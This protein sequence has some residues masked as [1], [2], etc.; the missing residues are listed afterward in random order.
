MAGITYGILSLMN[1]GLFLTAFHFNCRSCFSKGLWYGTSIGAHQALPVTL[2]AR[3][4]PRP[5]LSSP[6]A[7]MLPHAISPVYSAKKHPG[8]SRDCG[9][10]EAALAARCQEQCHPSSAAL[11]EDLGQAGELAFNGWLIFKQTIY[12]PHANL[13][14]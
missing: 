1:L 14:Y 4:Q 10:W 5:H 12:G 13:P 3:I 8:D 2:N 7:S 9:R 6:Q 11:L